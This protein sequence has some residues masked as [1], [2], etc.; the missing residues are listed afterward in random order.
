MITVGLKTLLPV[1][2]ILV[3]Q[4]VFTFDYIVLKLERNNVDELFCHASFQG[5]QALIRV[6]L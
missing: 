4:V 6:L 3:S 1:Q 5:S 2:N